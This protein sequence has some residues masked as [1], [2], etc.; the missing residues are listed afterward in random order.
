MSYIDTNV[1]NIAYMRHDDREWWDAEPILTPPN[2]FTRARAVARGTR[3]MQAGPSQLWWPPSQI[4]GD[5]TLGDCS[6]MPPVMVDLRVDYTGNSG[7]PYRIRG[8][9]IDVNG[10]GV[11]NAAMQLFRTSD[12]AFLY[13][14]RSVGPSGQYDLG[15][16]TNSVTHYIVGYR[17]G[18]DIEGTTENTLT[19]VSD[20]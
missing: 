17:T 16:D 18:P 4:F 20:G 19:G 12:D 2:E 10:D 8:L 7:F 9:A 11:G 15:V 14:S 3:V 13:E 6:V 1:L 5:E